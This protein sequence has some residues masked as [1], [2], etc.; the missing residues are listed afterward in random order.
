M[1]LQ[2]YSGNILIAVNPFQPL[3]HLYDDYMMERYKG[4]PIEGLS[5]HVFTIADVAYR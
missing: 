1:S 3:S 4:A 5:P 2:T